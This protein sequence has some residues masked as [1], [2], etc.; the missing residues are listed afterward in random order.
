MMQLLY[1]KFIWTTCFCKIGF[2]LIQH[3]FL[4]TF[5]VCWTFSRIL[6][7][8]HYMHICTFCSSMSFSTFNW[9]SNQM[10]Q[11]LFIFEEKNEFKVRIDFQLHMQNILLSN[12]IFQCFTILFFQK[13]FITNSSVLFVSKSK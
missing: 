3:T 9:I 6:I 5:F 10:I 8:F 11:G 12:W 13:Q 7:I 1:T 4:D 2:Q